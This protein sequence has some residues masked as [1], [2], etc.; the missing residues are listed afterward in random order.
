MHISLHVFPGLQDIRSSE[1]NMKDILR[2]SSACPHSRLENTLELGGSCLYTSIS[3]SVL[4]ILAVQ[5]QHCIKFRLLMSQDFYT[6][7]A[8]KCQN[9]STLPA[10]DAGA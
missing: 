5:R 9:F 6:V 1:T 7:L 2:S 4:R 3:V 10:L 8:K